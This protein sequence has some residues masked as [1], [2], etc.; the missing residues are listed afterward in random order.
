M[1]DITKAQLGWLGVTTSRRASINTETPAAD[2]GAAVL[3]NID[4]REK[5]ASSTM[6]KSRV[7]TVEVISK[8]L[9]YLKLC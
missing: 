7:A 9:N 6:V 3:A 1:W 8:D 2:Q 4:L 5:R